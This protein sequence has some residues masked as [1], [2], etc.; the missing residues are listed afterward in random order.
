M[1]T[2]HSGDELCGAFTARFTGYA[3]SRQDL[4]H[5]INERRGDP[6][7]RWFKAAASD[8]FCPT[9]ERDAKVEKIRRGEG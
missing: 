8:R 4:T 1:R 5:F 3:V 7:H 2:L 6:V 9:T